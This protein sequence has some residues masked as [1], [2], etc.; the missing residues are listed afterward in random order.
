MRRDANGAGYF[1]APPG[2]AEEMLTKFLSGHEM[3][4]ECSRR[5]EWVKK[6][7]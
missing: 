3:C 5:R 1:F 7:C 6:A 2:V 4:S